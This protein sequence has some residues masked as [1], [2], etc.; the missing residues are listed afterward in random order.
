MT[1]NPLIFLS[2]VAALLL[3][4]LFPLLFAELMATSLG[5]LHLSPESAVLLVI[6]IMVGGLVNIPVRR[7]RHDREVEI[8]PLAAYG[9]A[10]PQ[11]RPVRRETI[12][13]VNLG[14]CLVPTGLAIY[15]LGQ[16]LDTAPR[17]LWAVAVAAGL[18][19]IACYL[20]ARPVPGLGIAL[21][22]LVPAFI[23][24][25]LA[26][27]LA[28]EQAAPVAFIAG[29]IGPL[30]GADL[31]HLRD[32]ERMATGVVSIGGAGTFDGIVLSGIVAAYLA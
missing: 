5:K 22:G 27:L 1:M 11:L 6:A 24:A 17:A 2:L 21:P 16:L 23:A 3:L 19:T 31:L 26:L 20:M 30:A 32:V 4:A 13:A 15:E 9:M 28:G 14:G 7:V 29:V 10:W 8:H 25:A 12:V 18:N